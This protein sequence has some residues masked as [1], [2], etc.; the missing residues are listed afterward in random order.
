M[1]ATT[2]TL[3]AVDDN[4][5]EWLARVDHVGGGDYSYGLDT[6]GGLSIQT[7][8]TV[9]AGDPYFVARNPVVQGIR[10]MSG[11]GLLP[12]LANLRLTGDLAIGTVTLDNHGDQS[13]HVI[14]TVHGPGTTFSATSPTGELLKWDSTL[15]AGETLTID[16]KYATIVDQTGAN[17]YAELAP[18][19]RFWQVPS[20]ISTCQIEMDL[21]DENSFITAA[22]YPRTWSVI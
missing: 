21:V 14:W 4:G 3:V 15:A 16:T 2:F 22:W 9:Q 1:L 20:G 13:A 7:A 19:P 18:A 11:R 17:R 10:Q 8:V 6:T 5:D 12:D